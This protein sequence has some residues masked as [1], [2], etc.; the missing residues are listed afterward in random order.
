MRIALAAGGV[1]RAGLGHAQQDLLGHGDAQVVFHELRV[2]QAGERPDAGD[3]G[4]PMALDAFE[5]ALQ[6][7]QV[8]DGWVMAYSAPASTLYLKRRSSCSMSGTPGLAATPMVKL[9][10][11][12]I[13]LAPMSRPWF[14][15]RTILTRPMES[16]RRR[17]WRR[18]SC[19]AWA[20][21]RS[22]RGYCAGRWTRPR[23]VR[24]N[25]ENIAVAA[26][27]MEDRLDARCVAGSG[28]RGSARSCAP[29]R[30]ASRAH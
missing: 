30:A 28:C 9:V 2:A 8:E 3:N 11:A 13:A 14:S 7:A 26:G 21:R 16:R 17:L 20:D 29:R 18:D 22:G 10:L 5:K 15:L 24:L 19:P 6:Q 1:G 4:N 12:P 23:A 27:V 25:G